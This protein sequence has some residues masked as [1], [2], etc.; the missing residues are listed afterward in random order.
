MA[1]L[2][3]LVTDDDVDAA[4][5]LVAL[6]ELGGHEVLV[7]YDGATAVQTAR[8]FL[9]DLVFLDINMPVMDGY[10]AAQVIRR[11]A[12]KRVMLVALTAAPERESA[13]RALQSGFD[14]H[15][16]KPLPHEALEQLVDRVAR[17]EAAFSETITLEQAQQLRQL[18]LSEG[19]PHA[20][21]AARSLLDRWFDAERGGELHFAPG[22]RDILAGLRPAR[23]H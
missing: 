1:R 9:P 8:W 13:E 6:L 18:I 3:I 7:A 20:V 2:R 12:G 19:P 22:T 10:E 17:R 15:F 5:A 11:D 4:D 16:A 23:R 14:A 21:E